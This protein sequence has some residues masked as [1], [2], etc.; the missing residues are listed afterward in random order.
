MSQRVFSNL[1]YLLSRGMNKILGTWKAL[2]PTSLTPVSTKDRQAW[3]LL[4]HP[5]GAVHAAFQC[6][7][8]AALYH[9][10]LISPSLYK[11]RTNKA[12]VSARAMRQ[13]EEPL[14]RSALLCFFLK[15]L[16]L[17]AGL[18]TPQLYWDHYFLLP[19]LSVCS[20]SCCFLT[21]AA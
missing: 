5:C 9:R 11:N 20:T 10:A 18:W 3:N 21:Y 8:W 4:R 16:L 17:Q 13:N 19:C 1:Q 7:S 14:P 2:I 6:N 12:P 15:Q